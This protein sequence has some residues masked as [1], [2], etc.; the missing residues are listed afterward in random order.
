MLREAIYRYAD[1]TLAIE[2]RY[3]AV[4]SV[5][6]RE[7]P[8]LR[9]WS[10]GAPVVLPSE[11]SPDTAR[12]AVAAIVALDDSHLLIQGPPGAG[13]THVSAA[14]IVELLH[15]GKRVGV[16]SNSHKAINK[17]LEKVAEEAERRGVRFRGVKKCSDVEHRCPAAMITNVFDNEE[18][19][20]TY[21]LI[22]GTA[23][24]FAR[25][26][27]DQSL[28]YL[29]ID[30]AGQVSLGN[31][32]AMGLA[33][34]NLVLVGDQMQLAQPIQG[35]HPGRTGLSALE[36]LLEDYATVPPERG[37][38][39]NVTRRM[40]P[41]VCRFISEAVYE[42]HLD[43]HGS[44]VVQRL[45]LRKGADSALRVS[46]LSF[47]PVAHENCRQK[48]EEEARRVR[49]LLTSLMMQ[50]W[51]D[52]DGLE[53]PLTL[54]DILIV[55]PYNM[56]VDLLKSV[57]PAGARVGTVDKFQG[58][59]AAVVIVSMTTSSAEDCPRGMDFLYSRNRLNV[60]ISRA[61]ALAI[62]LASPRLLEAP[63]ATPEEVALVNTLCFAKVYSGK[64][65]PAATPAH[66]R[67]TREYEETTAWT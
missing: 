58:Q 66:P 16:S 9:G 14:A 11:D 59:E 19:N 24:L 38:F 60:A 43:S 61:R 7:L 5:L 51:V 54:E 65:S 13:K 27:L 55:S 39:L 1:A 23:W 25:Q 32:I 42:G 26:E 6:K 36:F 17:L 33:A 57:L 28:D 41:D 21:H 53:R 47:V 62:V 2:A 3:G 46:G 12:A 22:A 31:L 15:Q 48:S 52:Q 50:R 63:C 67:V 10:A 37:V 4:T 49:E 35:T 30:E 40:H 56:Q 8:K 44:T 29:F 18:V 45:I 34:R 20:G 64:E